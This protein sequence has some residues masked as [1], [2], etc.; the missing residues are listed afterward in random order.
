MGQSLWGKV[1]KFRYYVL[2]ASDRVE[3]GFLYSA[4]VA[5]FVMMI[6]TTGNAVGRYLYNEPIAG[7]YE[8]TELY[9]MPMAIFLTAAH[10]QREGGN[11]NVDIIYDRLPETAQTVIDLVGRVLAVVIFVLIAYKAGDEFWIGFING[12]VTIGVVAFPLY[13]SWFVM[14]VGLLALAVRL[15]VQIGSD[16][17]ELRELTSPTVDEVGNE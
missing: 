7:T 8:F 13:L 16:V 1:L 17:W 9:L 5:L 12:R 3:D 15:L 14:A 6:L 2:S 11:I 4:M 10:L